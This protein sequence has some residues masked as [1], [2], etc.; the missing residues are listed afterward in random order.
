MDCFTKRF[1]PHAITGTSLEALR[2]FSYTAILPFANHLNFEAIIPHLDVLDVQLAPDPSSDILNDKSRIGRA[3]MED[4]WQ[5]LREA[6]GNREE[7]SNPK[8]SSETVLIS[9]Q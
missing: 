3:Q 5:E 8:A 6:Y 2:S 9:K 1:D 7:P 4:C